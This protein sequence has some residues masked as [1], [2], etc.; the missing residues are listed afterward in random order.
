MFYQEKFDG[1]FAK[2][3]EA[4]EKDPANEYALGN[5]GLIYMMRQDHENAIEASSKALTIIDGF[6]NETKSFSNQN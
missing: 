1:A 6:Q 2:Y 3:Q 5:M 4:L